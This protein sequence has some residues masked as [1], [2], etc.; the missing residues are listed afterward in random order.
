MHAM[1]KDAWV[2]L[3][4]ITLLTKIYFADQR[5]VVNLHEEM[6]ERGIPDDDVTKWQLK[7]ASQV[8]SRLR[9]SPRQGHDRHLNPSQKQFSPAWRS[10]SA[11]PAPRSPKMGDERRQAG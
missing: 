9:G 3:L 10:S 7:K 4:I 1:V 5:K 11:G 6:R 2:G 8:R